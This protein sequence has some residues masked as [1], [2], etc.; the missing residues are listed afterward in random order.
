M[1]VC[2]LLVALCAPT[3]DPGKGGRGGRFPTLGTTP[4]AWP[5][6]LPAPY[7]L[8]RQGGGGFRGEHLQ[9]VHECITQTLPS[10]Q[11]MGLTEEPLTSTIST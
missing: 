3:R 8:A 1:C 9:A 2:V 4:I 7:P 6:L 10:G 5:D 11:V